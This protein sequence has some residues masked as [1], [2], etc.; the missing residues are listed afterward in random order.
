MIHALVASAIPLLVFFAAWWQRGR[1]TSAR[2]LLLLVTGCLVSSAWAV[3]PDMPRLW[4]DL[5]YYV[6]LHHRGYCNVWWGHCAIDARDEIDSSM[7]FP[8]LF[9]IATAAV[10]IVTWRELALREAERARE[11]VDPA[12]SR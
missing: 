2:A 7:W 9:V 3:V 11:A 5:E 1:R 8:V 12:R 4:G 6:D 10:L